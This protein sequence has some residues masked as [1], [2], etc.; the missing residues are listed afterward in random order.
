ML[1]GLSLKAVY[2][3]IGYISLPV[4]C[5]ALIVGWK[6]INTRSLMTLL[7]VV[8][9]VDTAMVDTA[10]GWRNGYYIWIFLYSLLYIYVVLARR[11]IVKKLS[12]ISSFCKDVYENYYFSK[13]E[14][15]LLFVYILHVFVCFIALFE[16]QLFQH[17]VIDTFP[18]VLHFFSPLLTLLCLAEALLVLKLATRTVPV[19]EHVMAL[20]ACRKAEKK[21]LKNIAHKDK[22]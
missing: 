10:Y 9:A 1:E 5:I 4:L 20:K 14:G 8:E 12:N 22:H 15:A 11:L 17:Y 7:L 18:Y 13:Q 16:V 2:Q 21:R 3:S 19:D 6:S